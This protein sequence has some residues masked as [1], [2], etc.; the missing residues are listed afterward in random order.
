MMIHGINHLLLQQQQ[1][2]QQHKQSTLF[3]DVVDTNC[4]DTLY[5]YFTL[6]LLCEQDELLMQQLVTQLS[7]TTLKDKIHLLVTATFKL[8]HDHYSPL[9]LQQ[10]Q[11]STSTTTT[12]VT[13]VIERFMIQDYLYEYIFVQSSSSSSTASIPPQLPILLTIHHPIYNHDQQLSEKLNLFASILE[14]KHFDIASL[15]TT[16]IHWKKATQLLR[17]M[18]D[19]HNIYG[20]C[21][22]LE[23]AFK[24]LFDISHYIHMSGDTFLSLVIYLV[25]YCN[26]KNMY[27]TLQFLTDYT[28]I[29]YEQEMTGQWGYFITNLSIAVNWWQNVNL[30][31]KPI[32]DYFVA[33]NRYELESVIQKWNI[34]Y[35]TQLL[36]DSDFVIVASSSSSIK[37]RRNSTCSSSEQQESNLN[38]SSSSSSSSSGTS[39]QD[40]SSIDSIVSS[41]SL[42]EED[43]NIT[44]NL[45]NPHRWYPKPLNHKTMIADCVVSWDYVNDVSSEL[46]NDDPL[47]TNLSRAS[48]SCP[49]LDNSYQTEGLNYLDNHSKSGRRR[50]GSMQKIGPIFL[51]AIDWMRAGTRKRRILDNVSP[52]QMIPRT[53][54]P[55]KQF[56]EEQQT[57]TLDESSSIELL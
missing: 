49:D 17:S 7:K 29:F 50:S 42:F 40:T 51:N 53:S 41:N 27:S 2:Q 4:H 13:S 19:H 23:Q 39:E 22:C 57:T 33:L 54:S 34:V 12:L 24:C 18:N 43:L 6:H 35:G 16:N 10:Q 52:R 32:S 21:T 38:S 44:N 9:L 25:M 45:M 48:I 15:D 3:N 56:R 37:Q 47:N 5:S 14:P 1:Q 20:K 46:D 31:M 55:R 28:E 36:P 26:I 11:S 8:L 30:A